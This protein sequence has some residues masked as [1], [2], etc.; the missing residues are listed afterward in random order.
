MS[1]VYF[2]LGIDLSLFSLL[3]FYPL[4]P[5]PILRLWRKLW[6]RDIQHL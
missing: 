1:E 2:S 5:F 4:L 3:P 6:L